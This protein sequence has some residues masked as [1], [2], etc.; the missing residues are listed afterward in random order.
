MRA[1]VSWPLVHFG[2]ACHETHIDQSIRA[3]CW[4]RCLQTFCCARVAP[5]VAVKVFACAYGFN[6]QPSCLCENRARIMSRLMQHPGRRVCQ[7][8]STCTDAIHHHSLSPPTHP[9]LTCPASQALSVPQPSLAAPVV[10]NLRW[11]Q[12]VS[13]P[14][15]QIRG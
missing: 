11:L 13:A 5:A 9:R 7:L 6:P 3:C 15:K 10:P 2:L 8:A 14:L 12:S 1:Q 4:H